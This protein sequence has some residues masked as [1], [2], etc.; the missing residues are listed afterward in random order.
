[1]VF[2]C[3]CVVLLTHMLGLDVFGSAFCGNQRDKPWISI[4][5]SVFLNGLAGDVTRWA[6]CGW[7]VGALAIMG[8]HGVDGVAVFH[9][10]IPKLMGTLLSKH[11]KTLG[12][13]GTSSPIYNKVVPLLMFVGLDKHYSH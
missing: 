11:F 10:F 7:D 2:A 5:L 1:M 3:V 6:R 4:G 12:F 8:H 13:W 9:H